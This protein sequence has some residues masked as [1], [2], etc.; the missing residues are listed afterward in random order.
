[1]TPILGYVVVGDAGYSADQDGVLWL[2]KT[3]VTLFHN[4]KAANRAIQRTRAYAI[5]HRLSWDIDRMVV[6]P[7]RARRDA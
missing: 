7:L 6:R 5:R 3:D 1:M 2:A 4:R